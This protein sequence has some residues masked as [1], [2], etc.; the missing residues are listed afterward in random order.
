MVVDWEQG[1]GPSVAS[2]RRPQETL[3]MG[4]GVLLWLLGVPIPVVILLFA[5]HIIH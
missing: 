1:R 3:A 4:K 5:F 2:V